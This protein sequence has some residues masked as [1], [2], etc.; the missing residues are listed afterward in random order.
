[1]SCA[2]ELNVLISNELAKAERDTRPIAAAIKVLAQLPVFGDPLSA[3]CVDRI[4]KRLARHAVWFQGARSRVTGDEN[5]S[6]IDSDFDL[7]ELADRFAAR[8]QG[9]R[10]GVIRL[11][12]T[13]HQGRFTLTLDAVEMLLRTVAELLDETRSLKTDLMEHDADRASREEGWTASTP[14]EVRKLFARL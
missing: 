2:V 5:E 12:A 4:S 14:E 13:L 9:L 7:C 8:L 11:Q 3:L 10:A 6:L 1:M